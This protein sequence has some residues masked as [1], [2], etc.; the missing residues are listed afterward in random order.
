MVTATRADFT[1]IRPVLRT[2]LTKKK[3]KE[4]RKKEKVEEGKLSNLKG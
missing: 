4:K 3:K 1:C 2:C